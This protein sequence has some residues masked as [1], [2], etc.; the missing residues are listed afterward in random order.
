MCNRMTWRDNEMFLSPLFSRSI[1]HELL[2]VKF[3]LI[4]FLLSYLNCA[5]AERPFVQLFV[6]VFVLFCF[7]P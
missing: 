3:F 6:I 1:G 4:N 2:Y 7:V 5:R